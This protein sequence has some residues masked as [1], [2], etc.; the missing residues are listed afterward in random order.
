MKF[1]PTTEE[2]LEAY[3]EKLAADISQM[4]D[5]EVA[6]KLAELEAEEEAEKIAADQVALGRFEFV[7]CKAGLEDFADLLEKHAGDV[8]AAIAEYEEDLEKMAAEVA[9]AEAHAEDLA[10]QEAGEAEGEGED[11]SQSPEDVA[12]AAAIEADPDAIKT[13]ALQVL[14]ARGIGIYAVD[15]EGNPVEELQLS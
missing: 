8:D 2:L 3:S 13:A 7:G 14:K 5:E 6:E 4:S 10:A 12:L 11:L 1:N 15:D 9:E